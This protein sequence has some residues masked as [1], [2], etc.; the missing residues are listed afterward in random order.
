MESAHYYSSEWICLISGS[1]VSAQWTHSD[2]GST[3]GDLCVPPPALPTNSVGDK[4]C[5][6]KQ[7]IFRF[8]CSTLLSN[9]LIC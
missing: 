4:T 9:V 3:S 2:G 1:S 5:K 7:V 6:N 8:C